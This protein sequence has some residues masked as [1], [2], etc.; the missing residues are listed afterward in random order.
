MNKYFILSIVCFIIGGIIIGFGLYTGAETASW[1]IIIPPIFVGSGWPFTIGSVF[2]FIGFILMY[3]GFFSRAFVLLDEED[4]ATAR[5]ATGPST[6]Q[7]QYQQQ[8]QHGQ[9]KARTS[10][11]IKT[12]GVLF[13][14]PI[15]IIWGSDKKTGYIMAVVSL[16]LVFIFLIF[17]LTTIF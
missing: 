9:P 2:I 14:G 10:T 4:F 12:G 17:V 15:P 3:I 16:V 8:T 13:I 7:P 5:P 11:S 1:A 6:K